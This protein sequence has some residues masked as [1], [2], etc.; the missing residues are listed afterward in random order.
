M[1]AASK[2]DDSDH[3]ISRHFGSY[4]AG[5]L[6]GLR[7]K[8]RISAQYSTANLGGRDSTKSV[9]S[10]ISRLLQSTVMYIC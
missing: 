8:G 9:Y 10:T 3:H 6:R 7:H 1:I 4:N 2:Q 5:T